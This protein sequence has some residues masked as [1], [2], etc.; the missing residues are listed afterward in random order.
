MELFMEI[1]DVLLLEVIW[2]ED[3]KIRVKYFIQQSSMPKISFDSL[4]KNENSSSALI[5]MDI[6]DRKILSFMETIQRN[7]MKIACLIE[8]SKPLKP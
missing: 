5:F 7:L 2:T 8:T 4:Q 6:Q 3:G 1:H